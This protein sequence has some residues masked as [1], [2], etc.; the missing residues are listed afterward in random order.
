M[1]LAYTLVIASQKL[2]P[3]FQAYTIEVLTNFPLRQVLQKPKASG[4]IL[5]W[6][7]KTSQFDIRYKPRTT[8][9][10]QTLADFVVEFMQGEE[11]NGD[12]DQ[13]S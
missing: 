1:K 10:G 3:Y 4:R 6:A 8:I 12:L 7:I 11:N 13:G 5:K 9:K 2:R